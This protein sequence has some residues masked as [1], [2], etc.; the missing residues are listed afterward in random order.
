MT[1]PKNKASRPAIEQAREQLLQ[2]PGLAKDLL[3]CAECPLAIDWIL[4]EMLPE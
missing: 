2:S 4:G 3:H 1:A